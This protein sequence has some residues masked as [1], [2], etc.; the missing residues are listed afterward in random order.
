VRV[1]HLPVKETPEVPWEG[2]WANIEAFGAD[3]DGKQDSSAALQRAIDSGADTIYL[4]AGKEF[5]FNSE[6]ILR[7]PV[8]RIIGLE[9]RFHT[10]GKAVWHLVDG[11]NAAPTVMI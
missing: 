7:G 6:V 5:F 11:E 10:E 1:T 8:K 3:G 4:P 2:K 9:G